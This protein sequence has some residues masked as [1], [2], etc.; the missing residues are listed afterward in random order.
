[1]ISVTP[2]ANL[3]GADH[4]WLKA[5]HHFSFA[6]YYDPER[7]GFGPLRVWNDDWIAAGTGFGMHP[8]RD[9]EIITYVRKGA[10]THTDHLKNV[11]RTEAGDIQVMSAG[12]GILHAEHN[13]EADPTE[14]FQIWIEPAVLGVKPRW[15]QRQFPKAD[16]TGRLVP[17][18]SGRIKDDDVLMIHQD[19][20]LYGAVM[21]GG[22]TLELDI[23]PGRQ[24]YLVASAG[25]IAVN[26]VQAPTRAGVSVT[27]ERRL[28]I[29][30]PEGYELVL[31]DLPI[32]A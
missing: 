12:T 9:M 31:I 11:G 10:I 32:A 8:H 16:R 7:M 19:A 1:M 2:L 21:A 3:G 14:L 5:R 6:N 24:V 15:A 30:G 4:G 17:L 25:E 22:G 18:V 27:D 26:G 13:R 28:T 29:A 20:T 23:D